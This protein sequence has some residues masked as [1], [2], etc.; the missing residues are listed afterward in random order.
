MVASS[1]APLVE[2][3][4]TSAACAGGRPF[5]H[6]DGLDERWLRHRSPRWSSLS[7][8]P[9]RALGADPSDIS[10]GSMRGGCVIARPAGRACR[11]LRS[12]RWEP[13]LRTSRR[14]RCA[15]VA[16]SLAP[17]VELVETSAACAGSRP[18]GH[19]DG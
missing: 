16:S 4:E 1:L 6:L 2:L 9:Q 10:T 7:R 12:V 15:V 17:L 14:A 19:L 13:T 5:G 11:D 3:V 8:P 18:F